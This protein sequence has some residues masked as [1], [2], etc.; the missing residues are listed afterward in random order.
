VR[1]FHAEL[2]WDLGAWR[3]AAYEYERAVS[4]DARGPYVRVAAYNRVL[5]RERV[6]NRSGT[7][8]VVDG[9]VGDVPPPRAERISCFPRRVRGAVAARPA[10][11]SRF[12]PS[13]D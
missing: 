6:V 2:L 1:F 9:V 3:E 10:R 5:A 11:H 12:G 4:L 7:P 8:R 13:P